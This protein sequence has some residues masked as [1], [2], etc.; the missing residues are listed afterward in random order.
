[1]KVMILAAGKGTRL[2]PLTLEIP[3]V[4]LPVGGRPLVEYTIDWLKSYGISEIAI[5]LHHLGEKIK[6]SLGD[7][8][9]FG[10][11]ISYSLEEKLLGTAGSV[12]RMEHFFDSTFV[13]FYGDNL[14]DFDLSQ[15]IE[16][17]REKGA[18][19]TLAIF[20]APNPGEVGVV[21]VSNEGCIL[22]FVEKPLSLIPNPQSPVLG[23]SGIY[24]L[25]KEVLNHI[26][27]QGLSDFACDV[28]PK[29][30]KLGSSVYGFKLNPED[31]FIDIGTLDKYQKANNDV[32]AGKIRIRLHEEQSCVSG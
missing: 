19:A 32:K 1:M 18:M 4:L 16:F 20:E 23:S 17:H 27:N 29:L 25:E 3:K 2:W 15:M 13:V 21:E 6:D 30:I 8:S 24:V 10:A 12:K 22:S 11:K 26:P 7:G 31:Y 5:N 9:R 28:F 14:T